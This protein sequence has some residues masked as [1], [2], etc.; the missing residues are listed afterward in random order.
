MLFTLTLPQ[1]E[2]QSAYTEALK[3]AAASTQLKGFRR[4]KAP[5]NLVESNLDQSKLYEDAFQQ[6]FPQSYANYITAHKLKPITN[7]KITVKTA[8]PQTEWQIEV[9]IAEKPQVT[10]NDYQTAIKTVNR[11]FIHTDKA[12][13]KTN[14]AWINSLFEVLIKTCTLTVPPLLV[15]QAVD[16]ELA[17]LLEQIQKLGLSLDQYLSSIKKTSTELRQETAD[18]TTYDLKID[19]IIEAIAEEQKLK[20]DA[21]S[22]DDFIKKIED[23]DIR[24]R[25]GQD[26]TL[27]SS[28]YTTLLRTRVIEYLK[29]L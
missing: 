1:K 8:E 7:P 10:L 4:G 29:S 16:H 2:I 12:P 13:E 15:E 9:E 27:Q 25:I 17:H 3:K 24:Q 6:V 22:I 19:F 28:I 26:P 20:P 5:L 18:R 21:K 23:P 11:K 14:E